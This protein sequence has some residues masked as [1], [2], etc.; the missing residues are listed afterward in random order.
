MCHITVCAEVSCLYSVLEHIKKYFGL[1]DSDKLNIAAEEVFVNIASYAYPTGQGKVDITC[2]TVQGYAVITFSDDG[3][4]F[5]PLEGAEPDITLPAEKRN[6]GGLGL[7]MTKKI[8]DEVSY[9]YKNEKNVLTMRRKLG[10][11]K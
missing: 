11:I 10:G 2:E 6:I 5:N 8:M 1:S 3:M 7:L 9:E 4:P